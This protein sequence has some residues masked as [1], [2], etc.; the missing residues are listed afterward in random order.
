[1]H[2]VFDADP[3]FARPVEQRPKAFALLKQRAK[4]FV[5]VLTADRVQAQ[6]VQVQLAAPVQP[7]FVQFMGMDHNSAFFDHAHSSVLLFL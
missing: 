1:M 7:G 2:F 4:G 6:H 5:G 3:H